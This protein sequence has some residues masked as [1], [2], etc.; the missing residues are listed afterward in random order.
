MRAGRIASITAASIAVA[1]AASCDGGGG[2]ADAGGRDA[3]GNDVD[4]AAH[5]SGMPREDSGSGGPADGGSTDSGSPADAGTGCDDLTLPALAFEDV[6]PGTTWGQP[7]GLEQP[8]GSTDLYVVDQGGEILI[9]RDGGVLPTPFLDLSGVVD[10]DSERGLLG[11]AFHPDYETN[12]RFFVYYTATEGGEMRNIVAEYARSAGNPDRANATEVRR[13]VDVEDPYS[14][15]NGGRIQFGPDG[16][17]Y[18]AMGDGGLGGDPR[19]HALDT[20]S[21]FGKLLRL[22]VDAAPSFAAAGNPF[23]DGG[24]LPQIWAY[25]LRNPWRFSF[26]R[27]TGDLWIGDVGQNDWEEIDFQPAS[28]TGGENYGWSAYEGTHMYNEDRLPGATNHTPPIF[29]YP[30][31]P[32]ME[33]PTPLRSGRSIVGGFVYRGDAIPALRGWYLFGDTYSND[34]AALRYCDGEVRALQRITGGPGTNLTSFGEDRAGELYL[35]GFRYVVR[36]VPG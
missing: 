3:R 19:N 18:V 12:G 9:V 29:E 2:A 35:V 27:L 17:L 24:G 7:V 31:R 1:L 28:S 5:D 25:G 32:S 4:A 22:D 8:P 15:H 6:A 33:N 26:D 11:L 10:R 14:N 16:Y 23:A 30:H 13:L 20:G 21:L 34:L 36:I